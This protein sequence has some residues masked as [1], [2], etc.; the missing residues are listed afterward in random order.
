MDKEIAMLKNCLSI[1]VAAAVPERNAE[2]SKCE[3]THRVNAGA[4]RARCAAA[5]LACCAA[6]GAQAGSFDGVASGAWSVP[7]LSG[8]SLDRVTGAQTFIDNGT[9]ADHA[10]TAQCNLAGCESPLLPGD[11][12][13]GTLTWGNGASAPLATST[14]SFAGTPFFNEAGSPLPQNGQP[15]QNSFLL[16]TFTYTN[17][18][19]DTDSL[20]FQAT[21]TLTIT[22]RNV[23]AGQVMDTEI[24][25][26]VIHLLIVSTSNDGDDMQ[27][28]DFVQFP[29][30]FTTSNAQPT[31][32][33]LE[34]TTATFDLYG[35]IIGD[36][37][38]EL[39]QLLIAPGSESSGFVGNG[40][41]EPGTYVLLGTGFAALA[42]LRRA[43][44]S[45]RSAAALPVS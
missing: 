6:S 14:L 43:R 32:N 36:P 28:A 22:G 24:A 3:R 11:P 12:T 1:A 42:L 37:T 25:T 31:M 5:L 26:Q 29:A 20:I 41:P 17:G 13:T 38:L 18:A 45:S 21:F 27:N 2:T 34:G 40:A 8:N 10:T 44:R 39:T 7:V 33:V 19:S 4:W 15:P 16:G 35:A 9:T 23:Q 30:T